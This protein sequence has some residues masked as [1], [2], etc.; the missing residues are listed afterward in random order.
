[1]DKEVGNRAFWGEAAGDALGCLPFGNET[2]ADFP[3]IFDM[4]LTDGEECDGACRC[5]VGDRGGVGGLAELT[6]PRLGIN[7]EG[8]PFFR[9]V[10]SFADREG[11]VGREKEGE[12]CC[13]RSP[14]G[15]PGRG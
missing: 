12:E 9:G 3:W 2:D 15:E 7:F 6:V 14:L 10:L 13:I 4:P 8:M 1:M 11:L 5:A